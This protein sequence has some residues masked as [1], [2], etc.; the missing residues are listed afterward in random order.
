EFFGWVSHRATDRPTQRAL[1]L[2]LAVAYPIAKRNRTGLILLMYSIVVF[3]LVLLSILA[4][5]LSTPTESRIAQ[6]AG[7]YDIS[8][9][10]SSLPAGTDPT[11][12]VTSSPV[13]PQLSRVRATLEGQAAEQGATFTTKEVHQSVLAVDGDLVARGF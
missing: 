7:G 9:E 3:T 2:R 8:A 10:Y 4:G 6:V 5:L 11:T 1:S 13:G 12:A